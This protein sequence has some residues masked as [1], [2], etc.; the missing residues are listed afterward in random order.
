[1]E[2]AQAL[3]EG[4]D[5]IRKHVRTVPQKTDAVDLFPMRGKRPNRRHRAAEQCY[6]LASLDFRAHSITSSAA[7][8]RLTG[9]GSPS[10][11]AVLRFIV[12][13]NLVGCT[14]GRSAGFSPLR[15]RP[16]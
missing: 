6:E 2:L 14:T 16:V 8:C 10:A 13:P 5:C 3:T 1:A 12:S 9:T 11:L 7:T 4:F 15:I